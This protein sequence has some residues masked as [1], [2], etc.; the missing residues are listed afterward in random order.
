LDIIQVKFF[1]ILCGQQTEILRNN[2]KENC[3]NI[4][5]REAHQRKFTGLKYRGGQAYNPSS[6]LGCPL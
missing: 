6:Y 2:E 4:Q 1:Q 3:R 5:Q